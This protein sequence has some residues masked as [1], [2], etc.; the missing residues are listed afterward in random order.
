MRGLQVILEATKCLRGTYCVPGAGAS[1]PEGEP[2]SKE[3]GRVLE[4]K[5]E[6]LGGPGGETRR[7]REA[8]SGGC[9]CRWPKPQKDSGQGRAGHIPRGGDQRPGRRLELGWQ[10]TAGE[11][12][13][14]TVG[15]RGE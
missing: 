9:T 4:D 2:D 14:V 5:G 6:S 8:E 7:S 10:G 12:I 11:Q 3:V 13:L 1:S 15:D